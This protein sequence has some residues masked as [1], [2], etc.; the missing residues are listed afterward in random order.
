MATTT[1]GGS[2]ATTSLPPDFDAWTQTF[3]LLYP[4]GTEF[5]ASMGDLNYLRLYG[6]RIAI[7]W[8]T[9]IGASLVLLLVL[10]LL[11]KREKRKSSIFIMN[12]L[13]LILNTI[14]S[15]L[16]CIWLTGEWFDPY[17]VVS[18][19]YSRI[20]ASDRANTIASN[21]ILTLLVICI[22]VSLSLQV[23]VVCV[24]A[25]PVH[26]LL[27]MG[28]TT[29]VALVALGY[30]FAVQ[31][32]S[33][34]QTMKDEGMEP[35]HKLITDMNITQAV[36]IWFYC[37]VFTFKLGYAL[38]QR[39][40]LKMNQFG[41]MQVIFIMGCQTMIIPGTSHKITFSQSVLT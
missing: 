28:A 30:R 34:I 33:N 40:K 24:T 10:I 13:C 14:R 12:A 19:D 15:L 26:R 16:Q 23:W 9:Q 27:I 3:T 39:R 22:F 7:N 21:T 4:D 11:T 8:A 5:Q 6:F 17:T 36:A 1:S 32:I 41:P 2:P 29:L 31:T 18:A 25:K 20:T 37:C 38:I 35:Y